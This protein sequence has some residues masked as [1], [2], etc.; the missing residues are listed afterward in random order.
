MAVHKT[1]A[2]APQFVARINYKPLASTEALE[3]LNPEKILQDVQKKILK[4]VRKR[5]MQDA[6]SP[7]AKKTLSKGIKTK[8]GP[9]SLTIVATHP[10]FLPLVMGQKTGQMRWLRKSPTPIPIVLDSGKVIFRTA[11]ARSMND[12]KWVHPGR[13]PSRVVDLARKDARKIVLDKIKKE[14]RKQFREGIGK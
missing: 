3:R 2:P 5:I 1:P 10:A 6:F 13:K 11:S 12:G 9:R 7:E 14:L 8:L 4:A